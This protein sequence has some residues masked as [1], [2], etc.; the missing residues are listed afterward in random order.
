MPVVNAVIA[1]DIA[2][3]CQLPINHR[4]LIA[5]RLTIVNGQLLIAR[6]P[7]PV[8]DGQSSIVNH[9]W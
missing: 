4:R 8:V 3:N 7:L 5:L 9:Q 2:G 1:R 6:Y